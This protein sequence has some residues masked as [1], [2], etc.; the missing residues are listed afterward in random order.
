MLAATLMVML[1]AT[2]DVSPAFLTE[3]MPRRARLVADD[4]G[5][6]PIPNYERY[7]RAELEAEYDLLEARRPRVAIPAGLI[8]LGATGAVISGIAL[9]ASLSS[10]FGIAV[11]AAI[12]LTVAIV[13]GVGL[14][15]IGIIL[16]ART[17][18]ERR[19]L[20]KRMD[21]IESAFREGRC[22]SVEGQRPCDA[23]PNGPP[24]PTQ[25][26]PSFIPPQ[27]RAPSSHP[28]TLAVF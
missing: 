22:R 26:S 12:T 5:A 18:N 10:F 17:A 27:V 3:G 9:F 23:D 24:P 21:A 8:G 14:V 13:I 15:A 16:I 6:A 7:T 1:Q 11:Y 19:T 20:G 25:Q 28:I 4:S 2:P